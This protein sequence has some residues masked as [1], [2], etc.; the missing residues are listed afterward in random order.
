ML[1]RKELI[2]ISSVR[3][4]HCVSIYLPT[5]RAGP[6]V[7]QDPIRLKN[8][9]GEAE[10]RLLDREL[11]RPEV[12]DLLQPAHQLLL[13]SSFWRHQRDGLAL[14]LTAGEFHYYSTPLAF[15]ELVVV[16]ERFHIK[17]LLPLLSGNGR[18]FILALSQ[19][20]VRILQGTRDHV[21]ALDLE[22]VPQSLAE[23]LRFDV[24]ER[25]LQF[26][27][28]T[29]TPAGGERAAMFHG[30]GSGSDDAKSNL[31]R[32]FHQIDAGLKDLLADERAPLV[33]AG[34]DYLLPIYKEANS[35]S[36]LID[37]GLIGNPEGL[38][39]EELQRRAWTIVQPRFLQEQQAAAG[40]FRQW[41]GSGSSQ[42]VSELAAA[43][44]AAAQGRVDKLFVALG[45]QRWGQV[46]LD[47]HQ[48]KVHEEAQSGAED[49]LDFAAVQ[50]LHNG[51]TVYAVQ[52][53]EMPTD[54]PVAALLRY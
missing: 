30:H 4:E 9:L 35:Y 18:F 52:A 34:V 24:P 39:N 19:N 11:R 31:L 41:L 13:D 2:Q 27:T 43:V 37:E 42:A 49:L 7:R 1:T 23:A 17:P 3:A 38:S 20:D 48:I 12:E 26:H 8:L 44:L 47:A 36:E 16:T 25:Q 50:T 54:L 5:H 6:E 32:Y 51:G 21:A 28:S 53:D 40:L 22:D 46:D 33:L 10:Q 15:D 45:V 29:A 14:F